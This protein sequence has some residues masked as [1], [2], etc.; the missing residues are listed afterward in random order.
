MSDATKPRSVLGRIAVI[1]LFTLVVGYFSFAIFGSI[2]SQLYGRPPVEQDAAGD[3]DP[4]ERTWCVRSIVGL[5]DEIE[6]Q[7]TLELQHPK[8]E[9]DPAARWTLWRSGWRAKLATA[10]GRCVGAGHTTLDHAYQQ[11]AE[12]E[13]GYGTA[14][15]RVI[16]TRTEISAGLQEALS[17]LKKQR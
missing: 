2:V 5:R 17:H 13:I 11:L 7:V 6:G 8:R 12:L 1:S 14:V 3:L 4:R 16:R 15:D 9:G 10:R